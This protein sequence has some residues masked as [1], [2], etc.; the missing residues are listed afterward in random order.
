MLDAINISKAVSSFVRFKQNKKAYLDHIKNAQSV[1]SHAQWSDQFWVEVTMITPTK[2]EMIDPHEIESFSI[3]YNGLEAENVPMGSGYMNIFGNMSPL[4]L[5]VVFEERAKYE[6]LYR[7]FFTDDKNSEII[8]SDGTYLLP[9]EWKFEIKINAVQASWEKI[10][11]YHNEFIIDGGTQKDFGVE[12]GQRQNL[13]LSFVP[14]SSNTNKKIEKPVE[15]NS[16]VNQ[17]IYDKLVDI[18]M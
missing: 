13:S 11:V 15:N 1:K 10:G 9:N 6:N 5:D 4:K 12:G 7:Y 17:N 16:K 14:I 18:L 8:P 3:T 2:K